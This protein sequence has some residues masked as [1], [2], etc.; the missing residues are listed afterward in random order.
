MNVFNLKFENYKTF[1]R[2]I[3]SVE[4]EIYIFKKF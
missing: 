4:T 2:I 3:E 1:W